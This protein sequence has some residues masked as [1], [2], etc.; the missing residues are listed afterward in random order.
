[1]PDVIKISR[2]FSR[3]LYTTPENTKALKIKPTQGANGKSSVS[4]RIK[5]NRSKATA[6]K[7]NRGMKFMNIYS[8]AI[9]QN[10][11]RKT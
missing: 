3:R 9:P 2:V 5:R 8:E 11:S 6:I 10:T 7:L 4:E 1:M